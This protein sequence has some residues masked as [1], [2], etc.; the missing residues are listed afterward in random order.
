[1]S[2]NTPVPSEG[3]SG[4]LLVGGLAGDCASLMRWRLR[5]PENYKDFS[6]YC[7]YPMGVT[8]V[9]KVSV[10]CAGMWDVANPPHKPPYSFTYG[11]SI[12]LWL[13]TYGTTHGYLGTFKVAD[14]DIGHSL[15]EGGDFQF[16]AYLQGTLIRLPL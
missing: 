1:M 6:N 2:V 4:R 13:G 11:T 15:M 8:G 12:V 16:V 10:T 9:P 5:V 3:T 14:E 7:L